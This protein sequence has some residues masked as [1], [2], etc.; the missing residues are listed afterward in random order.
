MA[1]LEMARLNNRAKY[2]STGKTSEQATNI[3]K[4]NSINTDDFMR[5]LYTYAQILGFAASSSLSTRRL[6]KYTSRAVQ[7]YSRRLRPIMHY[8]SSGKSSRFSKEPK[9]SYR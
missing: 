5:L 4:Y 6:T 8:V 9:G 1:V 2:M 3:Q 7:E